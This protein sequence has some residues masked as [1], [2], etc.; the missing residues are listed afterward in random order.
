MQLKMHGNCFPLQI[1]N[2]QARRLMLCTLGN[3]IITLLYMSH[4]NW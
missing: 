2:H 4:N 3:A 1:W